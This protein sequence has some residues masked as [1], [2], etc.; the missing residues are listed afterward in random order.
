MKRLFWL[1]PAAILLG[2]T[3]ASADELER[4]RPVTDATVA[5]ECGSC[6]M[7]FQPDFLSQ[8]EWRTIMANL[9][10]H[11]GE[12]ASLD[13]PT[14]QHIES[15]LVA[16]APARAWRGINASGP[17][18]RITERRWW[19]HEHDEVPRR[20]WERSDVASPANCPACHKGAER[21][22]YEDD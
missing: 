8:E 14:R 2:T 17:L 20:V 16:R 3:A 12:N 7:A 6:H 21:G 19:V 4:V 9:D 15:W 10:D 5:E 22:W 18:P 1:A 13:A 11:F